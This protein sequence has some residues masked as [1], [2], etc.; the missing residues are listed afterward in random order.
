MEQ[1]EAEAKHVEHS[2]ASWLFAR[3]NSDVQATTPTMLSGA[4]SIGPQKVH[5][6]YYA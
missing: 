2:E 4:R 1:I 5:Q 3:P 6:G